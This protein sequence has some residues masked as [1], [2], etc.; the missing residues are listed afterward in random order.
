M[1]QRACLIKPIVRVLLHPGPNGI[2]WLRAPGFEWRD[3]ST[4]F[5]DENGILEWHL[6][7]VL[8]A[9]QE[10]AA[11]RRAAQVGT[12]VRLVGLDWPLAQLAVQVHDHANHRDGIGT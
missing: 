1:V 12:L 5:L 2:E 10:L 6:F 7:A 4:F 3:P 9:L 11:V 8:H